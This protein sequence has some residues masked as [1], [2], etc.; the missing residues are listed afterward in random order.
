MVTF[1]CKPEAQSCL[2]D[3]HGSQ[4]NGRTITAQ[5]HDEVRT[6]PGTY[7]GSGAN[8]V[9]LGERT[10]VPRSRFDVQPGTLSS[11]AFSSS[12]GDASWRRKQANQMAKRKK[13]AN[14]QIVEK[15]KAEKRKKDG[16]SEK[17]DFFSLEIMKIQ[18]KKKKTSNGFS[19]TF[20]TSEMQNNVRKF[21]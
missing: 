8:T 20:V 18:Q 14:D 16:I 3:M 15:K 11:I 5:S 4:Y 10:V 21:S 17:E 9:P 7:S 19:L 13:A 2:D 12:W 6:K 1:E